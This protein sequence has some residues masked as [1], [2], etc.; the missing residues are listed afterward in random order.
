MHSESRLPIRVLKSLFSQ[1]NSRFP[2]DSFDLTNRKFP[3]LAQ[4]LYHSF[5]RFYRIFYCAAPVNIL[6]HLQ[7]LSIIF[8]F[9][10]IHSAVLYSESK[11]QENTG[12]GVHSSKFVDFRFQ[13]DETWLFMD[14]NHVGLI[15]QMFLKPVKNFTSV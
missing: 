3:A 4:V 11:R 12:K 2:S 10:Y 13:K 5:L 1:G 7:G 6:K 15:F 9:S 14:L 8:I